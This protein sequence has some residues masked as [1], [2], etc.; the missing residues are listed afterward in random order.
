MKAQDGGAAVAQPAPALL[1]YG[2]VAALVGLSSR[3]IRRMAADGRFPAPV[4]VPGL[5]A[6]RFKRSAVDAWLA[7]R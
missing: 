1:T 3:S 7:A 4:A 6:P 2:A 5:R